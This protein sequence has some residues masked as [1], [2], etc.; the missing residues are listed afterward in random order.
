MGISIS[1]LVELFG[2]GIGI[3]IGGPEIISIIAIV[4]LFAGCIG[5]MMRSS[6]YKPILTRTLNLI[7][8]LMIIIIIIIIIPCIDTDSQSIG[9]S[10]IQIINLALLRLLLILFNQILGRSTGKSG[11][12]QIGRDH[13]AL[14]E[15]M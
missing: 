2:I 4:L 6:L 13:N 11:G 5:H 9:R 12:G 10:T 8:I 15:R 14:E 1:V 7:I 3:I